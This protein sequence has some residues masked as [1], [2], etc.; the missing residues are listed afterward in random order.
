M[1]EKWFKDAVTTTEQ[2]LQSHEPDAES[3][4]QMMLFES[5]RPL[6]PAITWGADAL[7]TAT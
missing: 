3:K 7:A 6:L 2:V 4:V 5:E 1:Q